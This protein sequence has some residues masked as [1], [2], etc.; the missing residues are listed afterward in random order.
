M[1][2][3]PSLLPG[4]PPSR[5]PTRRPITRCTPSQPS[6]GTRSG[7]DPRKGPGQPP[8]SILF[9]LSLLQIRACAWCGWSCG[10]SSSPGSTASMVC[11]A[12]SPRP[13]A[14]PHPGSVPVDEVLAFLLHYHPDLY[15]EAVGA[16]PLRAGVRTPRTAGPP[17]VPCGGAGAGGGPHAGGR[18]AGPAAMRHGLAPGGRPPADAAA[19]GGPGLRGAHR[20]GARGQ[21]GGA[22]RPARPRGAPATPLA[23]RPC[24]GVAALD[25]PPRPPQRVGEGL[26]RLLRTVPGLHWETAGPVPKLR[27]AS[28]DE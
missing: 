20:V 14:Q 5:L 25:G 23:P 10:S 24:A 2:G 21:P 3:Q 8:S 26:R 19:A 4:T 15:R 7:T 11:A 17:S 12:P 28:G 6:Q 27:L 16:Q 22:P 9:C 13:P 1:R 18:L